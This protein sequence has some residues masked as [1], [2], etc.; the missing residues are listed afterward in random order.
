MLL[1]FRH[2]AGQNQNIETVNRCF[3]SAAQFRYLGTAVTAQN[4]IL[5]EIKR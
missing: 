4:L 2:N 3:E 1:F 5:E